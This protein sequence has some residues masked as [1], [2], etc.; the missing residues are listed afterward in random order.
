MCC[1]APG[2]SASWHPAACALEACRGQLPCFFLGGGHFFLCMHF[3]G[4]RFWGSG[5]GA[6]P[7]QQ[8]CSGEAVL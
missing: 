1:P 8:V 2:C 7:L 3:F 4:N 5:F 6:P